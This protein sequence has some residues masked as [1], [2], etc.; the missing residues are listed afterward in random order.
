DCAIPYQ[1]L[2]D[3]PCPITSNSCELPFRVFSKTDSGYSAKLR[4]R[5]D[6]KLLDTFGSELGDDT[7]C[8]SST[9]G[10]IRPSIG[11]K[12]EG[13]VCAGVA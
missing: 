12:I 3:L 6:G 13:A 10:W 8:S 11:L 2:L 7:E 4:C 1:S 5:F 9:G